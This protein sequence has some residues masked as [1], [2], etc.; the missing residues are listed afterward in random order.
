M[1]QSTLEAI[2]QRRLTQFSCDHEFM[3]QRE[4]DIEWLLQHIE[5]LEELLNAWFEKDSIRILEK[6]K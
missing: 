1:P 2:K 6:T 3:R 4:K 5:S